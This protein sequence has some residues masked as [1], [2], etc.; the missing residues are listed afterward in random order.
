[1]KRGV[2]IV[3]GVLIVALIA[4]ALGAAAQWVDLVQFGRLVTRVQALEKRV[5]ALEGQ[6]GGEGRA[7]KA[8]KS[9]PPG[10]AVRIGECEWRVLGIRSLGTTLRSLKQLEPDRTSK[11]GEYYLVE[12][13]MTNRGKEDVWGVERLRLVD[14]R[15]REF[16]SVQMAEMFVRQPLRLFDRLRPDM[17]RR[18]ETVF[19]VPRGSKPVAIKVLDPANLRDSDEAVIDLRGEGE[20]E[21]G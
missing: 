2:M 10:K 16:S 8:P 9:V 21:G 13:E 6:A 11:L 7:P 1:M 3:A 18:F 5:D 12:A 4:G 20:K 19:E 14:D 17:S 15:G